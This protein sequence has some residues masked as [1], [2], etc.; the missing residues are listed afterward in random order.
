VHEYHLL[1]ILEGLL[2]RNYQRALQD[3]GLPTLQGH[4]AARIQGAAEPYM[5][6]VLES[7]LYARADQAVPAGQQAHLERLR[8]IYAAKYPQLLT[9][10]FLQE[11][12]VAQQQRGYEATF[13]SGIDRVEEGQLFEAMYKTLNG[14]QKAFVDKCCRALQ[15]Q[16]AR[17]EALKQDLPEPP[18]PDE[19]RFLH[20]QARGGRGK[21]YVT[22][23]VL[24]K[25]LHLGII[26]SVSS[27]AGIAAILLPMG[28]T[29]HQTYGLMLD[30][31]A[32]GH[33]TLT[34]RSAQGKHLGECLF[35]VIDEVECLHQHLFNAASEVTTRCVNARWGTSIGFGMPWTRSPQM[36]CTSSLTTYLL[37]T[38]TMA[39]T[40]QRATAQV[41]APWW[42]PQP[43]ALAAAA[44]GQAPC[45]CPLPRAL[46]AAA[47]V[48]APCWCQLLGALTGW[49]LRL[50]VL[51]AAAA[52]PGWCLR[53][54]GPLPRA[55]VRP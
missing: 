11:L 15:H 27:F 24:A 6:L 41:Q 44:Q 46:A 5:Q 26:A 20:L 25:A 43:R 29:C 45:L 14:E 18:I 8:A 7:Y 42:C 39:A 50:S 49:C 9:G 51:A 35:H 12:A 54:R 21:S 3:L 37:M 34:T 17:K 1:R 36:R 13:F 33:S 48:Q 2:E 19:E 53:M 28:R 55:F 4:A 38:W 10:E 52:A 47:Q 16:V 23:C 32:P 31:S 30:T 40:P 22:K